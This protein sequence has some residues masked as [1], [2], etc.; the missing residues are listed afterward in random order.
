MIVG[1]PVGLVAD[2]SA[3]GELGAAQ[4]RPGLHLGRLLLRVEQ[5]VRYSTVQHGA[6]QYGTVQYGTVRYSAARRS[7]V[8]CSVMWRNVLWYS[9]AQCSAVQC[10]AVRVLMTDLCDVCW[11]NRPR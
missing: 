2:P 4:N 11:D 1:L 7:P 5:Q 8:Q 9:A 6:V 10:S 3:R